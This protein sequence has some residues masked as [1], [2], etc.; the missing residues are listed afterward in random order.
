MMGGGS[1]DAGRSGFSVVVAMDR[2]RGIGRDGGLPWPKLK[3]DLKFFRELTT[4]PDSAAVEMRW[5]LKAEESADVQKWEDVSARMKL[6]VQ[7]LPAAEEGHDNT[8][9]MG[10]KTW[11][12]LPSQYQPLPMRANLV[13]SRNPEYRTFR[14]KAHGWSSLRTAIEGARESE[15]SIE[16]F[17]I[18]GGETYESALPESDCTHL[19]ITEIDAVFP[20]DTFFPDTPG[21]RPI[22]SSPWILESGLRY[23]FCRY[24]RIANAGG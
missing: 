10:R 18:G 1:G 15:P 20:C 3:G 13:L 19:Y 5:G 4:C 11:Q 6:G 22:L 8:V 23:R 2:N 16:M 24:D 17:V 21:F 7:A 9:I 12:S 14:G